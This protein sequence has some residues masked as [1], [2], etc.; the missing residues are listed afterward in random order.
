MFKI[1]NPV[2]N[3]GVLGVVPKE[4]LGVPNVLVAG[5]PKV[6]FVPKPPPNGE[7]VGFVLPKPNI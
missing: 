2:P 4:V 6:V 3:D 1:P 5:C 7:D